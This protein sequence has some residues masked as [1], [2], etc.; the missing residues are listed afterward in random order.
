MNFGGSLRA[1]S[2]AFQYDFN[3]LPVGQ[4]LWLN[5][6]ESY[7]KFPPS[8]WRRL[9]CRRT[10]RLD[11]QFPLPPLNGLHVSCVYQAATCN[12]SRSPS[13]HDISK[14][15]SGEDFDVHLVQARISG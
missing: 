1:P 2:T 10:L 15:E 11:S 12:L 8:C 7:Q 6:L 3:I 14:S 5:E 13:V 4:Q 9:V